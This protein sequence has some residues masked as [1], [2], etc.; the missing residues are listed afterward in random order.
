LRKVKKGK[1]FD[2]NNRYIGLADVD[3]LGYGV[4]R[5]STPGAGEIVLWCYGAPY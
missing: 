1:G 3:A 5:A 2:T 4:G